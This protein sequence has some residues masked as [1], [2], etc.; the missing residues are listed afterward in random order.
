ME[1]ADAG[2]FESRCLLLVPEECFF[3]DLALLDIKV[4]FLSNIQRN[5]R[6]I[7]RINIILHWLRTRREISL[8]IHIDKLQIIILEKLCHF[9]ARSAVILAGALFQH[10][11]YIV[12]SVG[13]IVAVEFCLPG[14]VAAG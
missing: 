3:G 9:R 6:P 14:I 5:R 1:F 8:R 13:V 12:K 7:L 2:H 10:Y 4:R 11:F